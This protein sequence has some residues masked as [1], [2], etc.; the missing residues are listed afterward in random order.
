M[1][2][3]SHYMTSAKSFLQPLRYLA[4]LPKLKVAWSLFILVLFFLVCSV[5]ILF[6]FPF[7]TGTSLSGWF[8]CSNTSLPGWTLSQRLTGPCR[9]PVRL[10]GSVPVWECDVNKREKG[11]HC[12]TR[13]PESQ[14]SSHFLFFLLHFLVFLLYC[15]A[16]SCSLAFWEQQRR[17][18]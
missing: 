13:V 5:I 12:H 4:R 18:Y 17:C 2:E 1:Q 3:T 11:H 6:H 15:E 10:S 7:H 8:S 14:I 16:L 9:L